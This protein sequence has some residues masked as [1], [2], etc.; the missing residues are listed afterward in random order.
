MNENCE[1]FDNWESQK[2]SGDEGIFN[3]EDLISEGH[4]KKECPYYKGRSF[5]QNADVVLCNYP[6]LLDPKVNHILLKH[7]SENPIA[8]IDEAHNIDDVCIESKTI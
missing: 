5:S 7:L 6:Y 2:N 1:Y 3:I 8:I 4:S